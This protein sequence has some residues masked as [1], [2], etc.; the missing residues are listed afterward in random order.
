MP[1]RYSWISL[2]ESFGEVVAVDEDVAF[3][4]LLLHEEQAQQRRLAGTARA[5]QKDEFAL[6]DGERQVPQRVQ[7]AAVKFREVV[8]LD[9]A[10]CAPGAKGVTCEV[11][12]IKYSALLT[13][14]HKLDT[15]V[16]EARVEVEHGA[17]CADRSLLSQ[18]V[19]AS[20]WRSSSAALESSGSQSN[21]LDVFA[22][23]PN[24]LDSIDRQLDDQDLR[25]A[26][27]TGNLTR[28]PIL[29]RQGTD[30][31]ER[32]NRIART[33]RPSAARPPHPRSR[34]RDRASGADDM[35]AIV[36]DERAASRGAI[37]PADRARASAAAGSRLP[38]W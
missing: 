23:H 14:T 21:G 33:G 10:A 1:R 12:C 27:L 32:G 5:G 26:S 31:E 16:T 24:P 34:I 2:R 4:R 11:G 3:A 36:E 28:S 9:H 18:M 38:A 8:R 19:E 7:A 25:P 6:V 13:V 17:E 30:V 29:Q 37:L 22:L 35:G 15:H 20:G